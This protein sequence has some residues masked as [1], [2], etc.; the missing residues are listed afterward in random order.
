M[1]L[2]CIVLCFIFF[3]CKENIDTPSTSTMEEVSLWS[4]DES[5]IKEGAPFEYIE[6][7]SFKAVPEIEDLADEDRLLLVKI[8]DEIRAYPYHY[9]N[10]SEVVN[11][12]IGSINYVAS[13]CPQTKSG[14]CFSGVVNN[15]KIPMIASGYL[16]KDNLVLSDLERENFWSQMLITGIRGES[17]YK[18]ISKIYSFETS[19]ETV[20][21]YFP[22]AKVYYQNF[23]TEKSNL[24]N[25][26]NTSSNWSS[27]IGVLE[28]GIET[29]AYVFNHTNFAELTMYE[30]F[31]KKNNIIV[32][33]DNNKKFF[34]AFYVP[35][36]ANL[37]LVK[38]KFPVILEDDNGNMWDVFGESLGGNKEDK[39]KSPVFYNA[40]LWA[41]EY[42]F[43][44]IEE[45][46]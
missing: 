11:D 20:K 27:Y 31:E 42:F 30:I 4:V 45:R 41:W 12:R 39:L 25:K 18:N 21:K 33:G 44:N 8:E 23:L 16:F 19:W 36:E 13:Y 26:K 17:F 10:Y 37:K 28:Y 29:K 32:V 9:L 43:E 46:Q 38:D 3:S 35:E 14:I 7:P 40:D 1:I 5:F 2:R 34:T 6:N 15:E 24:L 22:Q